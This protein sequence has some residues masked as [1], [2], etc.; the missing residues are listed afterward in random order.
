MPSFTRKR[1][2]VVA[3]FL[4][5]CVIALISSDQVGKADAG[6]FFIWTAPAMADPSG[7]YEPHS[8]WTTIWEKQGELGT[9]LNEGGRYCAPLGL[10]PTPTNTPTSTSTATPTFTPSFTPTPTGTDYGSP[11]PQPSPTNT[12]AV[13]PTPMVNL[14][15]DVNSTDDV[16]DA[17]PGDHICADAGGMCTLRAAIT[18]SNAVQYSITTI[19][20]P[21]G[22]YTT[23]LTGF[24][25]DANARGDLDISSH[26]TIHGAGSNLT[27]IQASDTPDTASERVIHGLTSEAIELDGLTIRN[28][29][30]LS[31]SVGGG[32]MLFQST[33]YSLRLDLTLND[34]VVTNNVSQTRGGGIRILDR[35]DARVTV[36]NSIISNI[37][38][39]GG[40]CF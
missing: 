40:V 12:M 28:G 19:N 16:Q 17:L 9:E 31:G 1:P 10:T 25:D 7:R 24:P 6:S 32:G 15:F 20:L 30:E 5:V 13:T 29:R 37:M 11:S 27:I 23:T 39:V 8:D 3:V 26:M 34:V 38:E 33:Q 2:L 14:N 22:T 21:A 18:E 35:G 4:C 36:N